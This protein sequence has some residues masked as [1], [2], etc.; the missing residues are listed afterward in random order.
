M[1][2]VSLLVEKARVALKCYLSSLYVTGIDRVESVVINKNCM[3]G[4]MLIGI[5]GSLQSSV[6]I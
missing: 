3:S 6:I 2:E 1:C 4:V 5:G